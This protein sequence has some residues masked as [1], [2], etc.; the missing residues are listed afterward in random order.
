M[1]VPR[2][3]PIRRPSVAIQASAS[4]R[5]VGGGRRGR[6]GRRSRNGRCRNR[7]DGSGCSRRGR[8]CSHR[9]SHPVCGRRPGPYG[10]PR[11]DETACRWSGTRRKIAKP[12]C[13]LGIPRAR[14]G[15]GG[16]R[17]RTSGPAGPAGPM[18]PSVPSARPP[19]AM[20]CDSDA[21][22]VRIAWV[23]EAGI[24]VDVVGWTGCDIH[25]CR[26]GSSRQQPV[27]DVSFP[28]APSDLTPGAAATADVDH[29]ASPQRGNDVILDARAGM[30]LGAPFQRRR[31]CR[32]KPARKR[33]KRS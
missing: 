6:R 31:R 29:R 23:V 33:K 14:R 32:R 20:R 15:A 3:Q 28:A 18:M 17:V 5:C 16:Q 21:R 26:A 19:V 7:R 27:G 1:S 10:R 11:P 25:S 4:R 2:A 30:Y 13:S 12:W 22:L 8:V 24:I 9:S